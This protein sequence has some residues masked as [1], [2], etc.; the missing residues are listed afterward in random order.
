MSVV[1]IR[2]NPSPRDLRWFGLTLF[3]VALCA[4]SV[5]SWRTDSWRVGQIIWGAGAGFALLYYLVPGLQQSL[6]VGWMYVTYPIAWIVSHSILAIIFYLILTPI[7][8][9]MRFVGRDPLEKQFDS[10]SR[11]YWVSRQRV[12]ESARYFKQY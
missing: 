5:I 4:G 8:I 10:S 1:E 6:Y 9:L 3:L 7:G 11:T 2:R 12:P